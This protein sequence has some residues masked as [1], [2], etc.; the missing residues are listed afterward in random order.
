MKYSLETDRGKRRAVN[1]DS[2]AV[3]CPDERSCFAIVC[4]GMG[5][6]NAGEIASAMVVETVV[7]RIKAGWREGIS[8]ESV[9]NLMLT[10]ITAASINVYDQSVSD[11][12]YSGMGTTVVACAVI[13]DHAI[14]AHAGDSRAYICDDEE[15]R[16]ITKDHSLVQELVDLGQITKEQA[17]SHPRKNYI[18]R[19]LGVDESVE[20]DFN[21]LFLS[22]NEKLLLCT[23]GLTNF[24]PEEEI[25][26]I[27]RDTAEDP[28]KRLVEEANAN[29]GGDN[30]TA[31]VISLK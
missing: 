9:Q 7:S 16:V 14:I 30:I 1:Q 31:V 27:L 28:A 3:F 13:D 20:I 4:D 11:E 24:V 26:R 19:A 10:S 25:L 2:C 21:R 22:E 23:D 29:G 15:L 8:D 17:K 5:G 6:A 12:K 18:T